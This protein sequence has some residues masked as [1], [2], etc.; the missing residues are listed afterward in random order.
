MLFLLASNQCIFCLLF[1][2]TPLILA[3]LI[4]MNVWIWKYG[5]E[6]YELM[7]NRYVF[8]DSICCFNLQFFFNTWKFQGGSFKF[9]IT[10]P[11]EYNYSPP[12]VKCLTRIWHPNISEE[13]AVCLSLLRQNSLDNFGNFYVVHLVQKKMCSLFYHF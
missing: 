4:F 9:S 8:M 12:I 13:G 11:P 5:Y 6:K 1:T 2:K 7:I 10:V 3:Y